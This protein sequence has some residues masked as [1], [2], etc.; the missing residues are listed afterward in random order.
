MDVGNKAI[1]EIEDK[2]GTNKAIFVKTDVTSY[3]QFEGKMSVDF[4]YS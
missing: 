1:Q 3:E 2:F 4:I